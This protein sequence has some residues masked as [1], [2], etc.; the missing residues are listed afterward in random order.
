MQR[1]L[2]NRRL[3]MF[4]SYFED[5]NEGLRGNPAVSRVKTAEYKIRKLGAS[6][7]ISRFD[8]KKIRKTDRVEKIS[9]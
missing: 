4:K 3:N 8:G 1:N 9:A 6:N 5:K 7:G 2:R